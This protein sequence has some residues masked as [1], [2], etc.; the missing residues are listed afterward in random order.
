MALLRRQRGDAGGPG[1]P[2]PPDGPDED[3]LAIVIRTMTDPHAFAPLY[4]KYLPRVI[5]YC[6]K[7]LRDEDEA[8]DAAGVTFHKALAGIHGFRGGSVE[9]WLFRIAA[10]AC[11]DVHRARRPHISL[12]PEDD[13]PVAGEGP[14]DEVIAAMEHE[15]PADAQAT[16]TPWRPRNAE[17]NRRRSNSGGGCHVL[18]TLPLWIAY[19]TRTTGTGTGHGDGAAGGTN[20]PLRWIRWQ[21]A[22]GR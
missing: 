1:T 17:M 19:G 6:T 7:H 22:A 15:R 14:E 11:T 2:D 4:R 8:W 13:L 10:H 16:A 21:P 9:A 5:G 20:A 12:D 18:R 3:D